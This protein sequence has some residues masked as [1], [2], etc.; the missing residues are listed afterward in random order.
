MARVIGRGRY[1][2]ETY[3][4]PRAESIAPVQPAFAFDQNST[5]YS[6]TEGDP[7]LMIASASINLSAG[8]RV[9]IE[10]LASFDGAVAAGRA[11]LSSSVIPNTLASQVSFDAADASFQTCNYLGMSD[12]Q[13]SGPL[14]IGLF[15]EVSGNPGAHIDAAGSTVLTLTE[16]FSS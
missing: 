14:T 1:V 9:K 5:Q 8:S 16:I 4:T 12:P 10:G 3:P 2:S 7:P 6:V 15:I 13:P 11:I